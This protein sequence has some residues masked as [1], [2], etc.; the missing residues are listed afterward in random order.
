MKIFQGF[1]SP[2]SIMLMEIV[3]ILY[4]VLVGDQK[5]QYDVYIFLLSCIL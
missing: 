3:R 4:L 1:Q 2:K 5:I